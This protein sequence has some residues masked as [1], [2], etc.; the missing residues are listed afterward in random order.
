MILN[1]KPNRLCMQINILIIDNDDQDL[2]I[3]ES[4][5]S[6][7][8]Y[9]NIKSEHKIEDVESEYFKHTDLLILE[10]STKNIYDLEKL[11]KIRERKSK[12]SKQLLSQTKVV[13]DLSL[14][15][16]ALVC[17]TL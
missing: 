6:R 4:F 2:N 8:H 1:L 17:L 15:A 14:S 13:K 11:S 7:N 10:V 16:F 12:T 9:F 5:F 3:L